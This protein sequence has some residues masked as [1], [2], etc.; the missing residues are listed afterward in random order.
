MPESDNQ[1]QLSGG[2][3]KIVMKMGNERL[4][5]SEGNRKLRIFLISWAEQ[6]LTWIKLADAGEC[7]LMRTAPIHIRIINDRH[8]KKLRANKSLYSITVD[9]AT[10]MRSGRRK[11]LL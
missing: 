9:N 1:M 6:K 11:P 8:L 10:K 2:T 5:N 4:F 3:V 7:L